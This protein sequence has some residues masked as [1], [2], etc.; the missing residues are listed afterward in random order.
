M[1]A[2]VFLKLP[3]QRAHSPGESEVLHPSPIQHTLEKK[4]TDVDPKE[5]PMTEPAIPRHTSHETITTNAAQP[6]SAILNRC[7]QKR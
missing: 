4:Q 7:C 3:A 5:I 2:P 6:A 1:I